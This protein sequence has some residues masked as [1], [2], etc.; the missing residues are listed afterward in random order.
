MATLL[1]MALPEESQ[2]RFENAQI[3]V[4]YSGIGAVKAAYL[5]H[6]LILERKP[7]RIVNLGT[8]GSFKF[9]QAE[10]V[11]C[12]SFVQRF[13][14]NLTIP[15]F[16]KITASEFL[17]NFPKAVCGSGDFIQSEP[18]ASFDI[19]DM[20]AYAIAYVCAKL[21]VSFHSIKYV[22]DSSNE[23]TYKD[24]K[25]NLNSASAALLEVYKTL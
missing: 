4:H 13:P 25:K 22:T 19:M 14:T 18:G 11:E 8:A 1:I 12:S 6:K 3:E 15:G 5:T 9:K 23:N 2:N 7:S 16:A 17:T 24:W 20:E 10:L 21:N